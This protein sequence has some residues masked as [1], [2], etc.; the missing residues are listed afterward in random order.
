MLRAARNIGATSAV[1]DFPATLGQCL[2]IA[3]GDHAGVPEF[4]S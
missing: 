1:Q 4:K 2:P 3:G